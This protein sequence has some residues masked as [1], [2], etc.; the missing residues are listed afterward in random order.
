MDF[1]AVNAL[2][3]NQSASSTSQSS[4]RTV[5]NDLGKDEFLKLLVAQLQN[6]DP[7][8]PM[9]NTEFIAQMAQFSALE[10]MQQLG[11]AFTYSQA[12]SLVGKTVSADITNSD[13]TISNVTGVVG[14]VTSIKGEP[15]LFID[16]NFVPMD[17][18]ITVIGQG[19]DE[20]L[21][22]GVSMIGKYIKGAYLDE[23]QEMQD[24]S[25]IVERVAIVDGEPVL[26]VG[27]QAVKLYNV[28]EVRAN[29][30]AQ[31]DND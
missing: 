7:T 13:G 30:P 16:G 25:G 26:Y 6:Q 8:N 1:N 12:Y 4:G 27:D 2:L 18:S 28:T 9:D 31:S 3:S 5:T 10:Q 11:T 21:L 29:A 17:S 23:N 14:G 15:Y 19:M 22:Q 24:I 20:S